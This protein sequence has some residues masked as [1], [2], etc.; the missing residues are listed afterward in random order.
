MTSLG[1][2]VNVRAFRDAGN[3]LN[4]KGNDKTVLEV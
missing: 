4:V 1:E 3:I 2:S